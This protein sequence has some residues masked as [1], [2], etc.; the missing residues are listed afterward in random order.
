MEVEKNN[1]WGKSGCE[2][3][4]GNLCDACCIFYNIPEANSSA[5]QHC[6]HMKRDTGDQGCRIHE[7]SPTR[8]QSF[9][10][11][12]RPPAEKLELINTAYTE[13]QVTLQ[14]AQ[15]AVENLLSSI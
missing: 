13:G 9:H 14:E 12:N 8:C 11:S 5:G 1:V 15:E 2:L 7:I 10:C 6:Q 3:P 4:D